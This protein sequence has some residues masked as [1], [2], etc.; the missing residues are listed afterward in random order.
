MNEKEKDVIL[1]VSVYCMFVSILVFF[2]CN[3]N[4]LEVLPMTP[5]MLTKKQ[6][7]TQAAYFPLIIP[8]VKSLEP[9]AVSPLALFDP[10]PTFFVMSPPRLY[11]RW[12]TP[13]PRPTLSEPP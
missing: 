4:N 12:T 8:F 13:E 6:L 11:T 3:T 9:T 10:L 5:S 2:L 7:Y 1:L